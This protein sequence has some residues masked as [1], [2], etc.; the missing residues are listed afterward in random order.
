VPAIFPTVNEIGIK[1]ANVDDDDDNNNNDNDDDDYDDYDVHDN[2]T[3]LINGK[4]SNKCTR[5]YSII[6]KIHK[7]TPSNDNSDEK[8]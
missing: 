1:F 8:K 4:R 2:L 3:L 6:I 5:T 7:A